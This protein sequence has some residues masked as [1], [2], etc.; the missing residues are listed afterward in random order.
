[1]SKLRDVIKKCHHVPGSQWAT[2]LSIA[3]ELEALL[4]ALEQRERE[5]REALYEAVECVGDFVDVPGKEWHDGT[6]LSS[7]Y[8]KWQAALNPTEQ[9]IQPANNNP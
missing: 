7:H 3:I 2:S 1:V 8:E 9:K 6:T 4:P 5:L